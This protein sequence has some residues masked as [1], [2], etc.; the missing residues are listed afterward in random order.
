M[1][2]SFVHSVALLILILMTFVKVD[3]L[4][5]AVHATVQQQADV[6]KYVEFTEQIK[7]QTENLRD[8]ARGR[9]IDVT[10]SSRMISEGKVLLDKANELLQKADYPSAFQKAREAQM[11]F[12]DAT[13]TLAAIGDN[14]EEEKKDISTAADRAADR[15]QR[16]QN[17]IVGITP[18][19]ENQNLLNSLRKNLRDAEKNLAEAKGAIESKSANVSKASKSMAET[20]KDIDEAFNTLKSVSDWTLNQRSDVFL[21]NMKNR[22][23]K[24]KGQL[25][26]EE[27]KGSKIGDLRARL[28]SAEKSI[29]EAN[30]KFLAGDKKAALD[31]IEKA[32]EILQYVTE[33]LTEH[34]RD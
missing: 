26:S 14:G 1:K 2:T 16:I 6:Q 17:T 32:R 19:A 7:T 28:S 4:S 13:V 12:R 29:Q 30:S 33:K 23:D 20:N 22:L 10:L 3:F 21:Q 24:M 15:I 18:T 9:G 5:L 11:T 31:E 25:D 27:R 34:G 8:Q